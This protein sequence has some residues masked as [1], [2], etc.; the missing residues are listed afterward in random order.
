MK[1]RLRNVKITQ[2]Q[3]DFA[4]YDIEKLQQLNDLKKT[5]SNFVVEF[6][7]GT[8]DFLV[9]YASLVPATFFLGIDYAENAILRALKKAYNKNLQNCKFLNEYI[10]KAIEY[11]PIEFFDIIY[12]SFPDPW[13]KRRHASRRLVTKDFLININKFIKDK[14][15]C[16][17]ITDNCWYQQFID[18]EIENSEI[19]KYYVKFWENDWYIEDE[20]KFLSSFYYYPSNYYIKAK[21]NHSKIR[22][23]VLKKIKY[24]P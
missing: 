9:N 21:S 13:P 7:C 14:G 4:F 3:K 16:I 22:F 5:Y 15:F 17:I 1:G 11:F 10:Q 19:N 6:C 18:K 24:L 2:Q 23:Y 20:E 12:I 8:G